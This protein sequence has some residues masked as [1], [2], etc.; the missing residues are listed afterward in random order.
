MRKQKSEHLNRVVCWYFFTDWSDSKAQVVNIC[1]VLHSNVDIAC[2]TG[3][4]PSQL[5]DQDIGRAESIT[6]RLLTS[7]IRLKEA[8]DLFYPGHIRVKTNI[9][10]F[11]VKQTKQNLPKP[12]PNQTR[13]N[14]HLFSHLNVEVHWML[15]SD[16]DKF[17]S[18]GSL[19]LVFFRNS[20]TLHASV[21]LGT[22]ANSKHKLFILLAD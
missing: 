11:V 20:N 8:C 2:L 18:S 5:G 7:R 16:P 21:K 19:F 4:L 3:P 6:A 9:P 1:F 15:L 14:L 10:D 12:K 13:P 22:T 17:L